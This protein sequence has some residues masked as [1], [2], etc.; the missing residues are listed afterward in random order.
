MPP[1][2]AV[3]EA[4]PKKEVAQHLKKTPASEKKL[5]TGQ[6]VRLSKDQSAV[7]DA[8]FKA[9]SNAKFGVNLATDLANHRHKELMATVNLACTWDREVPLHSGG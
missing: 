6:V 1:K 4:A 8:Q 9:L 7:V 5:R 2:K 3:P